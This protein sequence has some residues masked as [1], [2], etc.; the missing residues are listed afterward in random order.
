MSRTTRLGVGGGAAWALSGGAAAAIVLSMSPSLLSRA[1]G[2]CVA[3]AA[4]L[5]SVNAMAQQ[6]AP[7][8]DH[9]RLFFSAEDVPRLRERAAREPWKS[10]VAAARAELA[11][12][13]AERGAVADRDA[14]DDPGAVMY[15]MRPRDLALL[16]TL[17]GDAAHA[18]RALDICSEIVAQPAFRSAGSKGLTRGA[19]ALTVAIAYDLCYHAWPDADRRKISDALYEVSRSMGRSMGAGANN[20]LANNWAAVRYAGLGLAGLASDHPE[21]FGQA[22]WAFP[23]LVAHLRANL[24]EHG[25]NPEGIGY[26]IYPFTFTGPFGIAAERAGLG[27]LRQVVGPSLQWTLWTCYAGTVPIESHP[28]RRG[29]RPDL[30]DDHPV[31]GGRGTAG[32]AFHYVPDEVR[33]AARWMYD[34]LVGAAGDQSF[35][36][37]WGGALY[38]LLL[39][40]DDLEPKNPADAAGLNYT[41]RS[42]G[43][44][45]F[46]NRFADE[47]DIVAL[48]NAKQRHPRGGHGGPDVN[49]FRILGLGGFFVTGAGRTGDS[50]G[51]TN[52]FAGPP[53]RR[54]SGLGK[55][56]DVH[57]NAERGDGHATLTGS[58][59]GVEDFTR[60]FAVD[61]SG[62][63]G[64]PALFVSAE[65]SANGKLWRLNTPEFNTIETAGNSFT[66][67]SP[68]GP[69]LHVTVIHPQGVSFRTGTVE[70]GGGAGHTGFPY[71]GAK[72]IHNKWIEFDCDGQVLTV[73]TLQE[74]DP[75]RVEGGGTPTDATLRVGDQGVTVTGDAIVVGG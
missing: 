52:L 39:Y 46:R 9:P 28:G 8:L 20:S 60:R 38:G 58:C 12:L 59:V 56:V 17:E 27:D 14:D 66:L 31:W 11:A 71:R 34:H 40:P 55:L 21:G 30:S 37:D 6:A 45:I 65:T 49:T 44:A 29:L 72:Y 25:W 68:H 47:N 1:V 41:D 61:Y 4:L 63:S 35:D 19:A 73:M 7:S 51:Q 75:P 69:T 62:R 23:N 10:M 42:A 70:R 2:C 48:V 32:L 54:S 74:G 16:Y 64:A 53:P 3:A 15:D 67:R 22:K 5:V 24:G 26:T 50:A 57:F 43:V 33:P 36:R 13:D 18:R